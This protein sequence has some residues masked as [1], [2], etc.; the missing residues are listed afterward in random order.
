MAFPY[1][2]ALFQAVVYDSSPWFLEYNKSV[3]TSDGIREMEF[4]VVGE[5]AELCR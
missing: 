5:V 1:T 4:V 3:D 2:V